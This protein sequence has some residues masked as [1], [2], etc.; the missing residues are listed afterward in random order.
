MPET[1][2]F[3]GRSRRRTTH[4]WVRAGDVIARAVITLGGVGTILAVLLVGLY[5]LMV[6]LPL[7]RSARVG[8]PGVTLASANPVRMGTDESGCVAWVLDAADGGGQARVNLLAT[9]T[10]ERLV[11]VPAADCGLAG[12][13]AI[14]TEPGGL[15]AAV[16]F[17]DGT[18]RSGRFGLDAEFANA[19]DVP[20]AVR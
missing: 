3:T 15:V 20:E 17:E 13:S 2:T 1:A 6:A 11:A 14:R 4:P 9:A 8:P 12:W 18:F 5:L 16:G 7:A 19:E 10:G